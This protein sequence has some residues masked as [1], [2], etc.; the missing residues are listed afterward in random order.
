MN[1]T[2][3]QQQQQH[4]PP[5][6]HHGGIRQDATYRSGTTST[7]NSTAYP[8]ANSMPLPTQSHN[9]SLPYATGPYIPLASSRTPIQES[10]HNSADVLASLPPGGQPAPLPESMPTSCEQNGKKYQLVVV[11]QPQRARMCGFG[12]KDR[13]PITPPPC[14]KLIV[15]DLDTGKES[16]FNTIE[17]GMFVLNVDLWSADKKSEVNLVQNYNSQ[18]TYSQSYGQSNG[19]TY[20]SP[21]GYSQ[22]PTPQQIYFNTSGQLSPYPSRSYS[23]QDSNHRIHINNPA[24]GMFTRNLIGSLAASA[25]RLTDPEDKIGIWFVLQDLSVRTEGDFRLRFS[26]VNVSEI[27]PPPCT[28]NGTNGLSLNKG[29]SPVLARCFSDVFSVYSAKR[30]PGVV[31]STPLSRCF[32][33]QG[34]KIPIRKDA[35]KGEK[36]K[37]DEDD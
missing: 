32:A 36:E 12:D 7:A 26:F 17:H 2:Y 37:D 9:I 19:Q 28:Q 30:F 23:S 34:I 18:A 31:E 22:P 24:Q 35:A 27:S 11:Q 33:T 15:T 21:N 25:F 3:T 8:P 10:V 29:K 1:S 4:G 16:D 20:P 5:P 6:C 14:V 13:R